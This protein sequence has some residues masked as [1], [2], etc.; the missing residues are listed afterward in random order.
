M[1]FETERLILRPWQ[2]EDAEALFRYASD[3]RVGPFAGWMPH[4]TL[5]HSRNILRSVLMAPD[6][7]AVVPKSVGHAVGSISV[8]QGEDG[9]L[10]LAE[11]EAELGFWIGV[12]YWGC[13][14]IPEAIK[15]LLAHCFEK[16]ALSSVVCY[17]YDSNTKSRRAQEKCGFTYE[18]STNANPNSI[19]G[20]VTAHKTRLTREAWQSGIH[21]IRA[22]LFHLRDEAYKSFNSRLLPNIEKERVI[23]VRT[24]ALRRLAKSLSDSGRAE[25]FMRELPHIYFEENQLHAFL[26]EQLHDFNTCIAELERFLPYVDNWATCDQMNPKILISNPDALLHMI[27]RWLASPHPYIK[28]YAIGQLMKHFFGERYTSAYPEAVAS[29]EHENYYVRMMQAWYFAELAAGRYEDAVLWFEGKRL[30][31]WIHNKA[32]QKACESLKI[33]FERKDY[34]KSLKY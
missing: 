10:P 26:I 22:E 24:P 13:G 30:D 16:L 4:P 32:I 11:D 20:I 18:S 33:P 1:H 14:Y 23:G 17:Y 28:R 9:F 8:M 19:N 12:P 34:L 5:D 7:C 2:E 31:R 3:D 27:D 6:T 15:C 25:A 21:P 29:A